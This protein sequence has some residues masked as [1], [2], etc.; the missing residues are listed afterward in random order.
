MLNAPQIISSLIEHPI[1]HASIL[2]GLTDTQLDDI[3]HA[4][5]HDM[6]AIQEIL[7]YNESEFTQV[8]LTELQREEGM[9]ANAANILNLHIN[10]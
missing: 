10:S 1:H 4:I 5:E 6:E 2:N 7:L 9:Y 3:Y 8:E